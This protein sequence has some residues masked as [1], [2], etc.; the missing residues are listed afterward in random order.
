MA[1]HRVKKTF[2]L[3]YGHR[4]LNYNGKCENLHGHNGVVEVTLKAAGLN[5]ERM[6]MDFTVL[7]RKMKTWL[8]DNLDHKV[9]LAKADP[10]APVLAA[11]GQACYL[12]EENPTAEELAR[13]IYAEARGL[14]LPVEETG[15]W[16]TPTAMASYRE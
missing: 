16:E 4:L 3:A 7:G 15:F 11:Q 8:D 13:L 9:I 12:T 5:A 6:V 14:G 10:L 2:H 1:E